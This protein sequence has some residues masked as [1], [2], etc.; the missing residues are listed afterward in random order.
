M[1]KL[2]IINAKIPICPDCN[3]K[4]TINLP[5]EKIRCVYCGAL[6]NIIGLGKT[7]RDFIAEKRSTWS[8]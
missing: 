5:Q 3:S 8:K 4:M 1:N 6:L 7:D 2:E